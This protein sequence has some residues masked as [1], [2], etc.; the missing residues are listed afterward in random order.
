MG[1]WVVGIFA[2]MSMTLFAACGGGGGGGGGG[3]NNGNGGSGVPPIEECDGSG[4][5]CLAIGSLTLRV[6]QS[7]E[8]VATV[9]DA[10]DQPMAGV[11]VDVTDGSFLEI[12]NGSGATNA[13]GQLRGTVRAL[14]GGTAT[15][16]ATAPG[17]DLSVFIR[18]SIAGSQQ[19]TPT[20]TQGGPGVVTQTP[21]PAPLVA[22]IFMETDRFA[23]S[24]AGGGTVTVRA[25]AFDVDNQ[26]LNGVQLLF[27][28]EP[29]RKS[30]V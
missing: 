6:G 19:P 15:L 24:A 8:F 22:T 12:T 4:R 7:T 2:C 9:R 28:F 29:D 1:R 16:R 10:N 26:A 21:R 20:A 13:D 14:F 11:Q 18:I 3:N 17:E 5:L 23:V 30:V 25:F 27:D